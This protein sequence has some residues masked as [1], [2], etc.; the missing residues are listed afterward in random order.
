MLLKK[1]P[2]SFGEIAKSFLGEGSNQETGNSASPSWTAIILCQSAKSRMRY[3]S[4]CRGS[5]HALLCFFQECNCLLTRGARMS[6]PGA[7]GVGIYESPTICA[8]IAAETRPR[9]RRIR[10][11]S[12]PS[13]PPHRG[14]RPVA[15]ARFN[16]QDRPSLKH[17]VAPRP[18]TPTSYFPLWII[19]RFSF[20]R[21]AN[22]RPTPSWSG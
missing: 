18:L 11:E 4:L 17:G 1:R 10:P 21:R 5:E 9:Y 16:P 3:F 20:S 2:A 15:Y 12:P 6:S 14:L 19:F 8:P 13:A 22:N 7:T